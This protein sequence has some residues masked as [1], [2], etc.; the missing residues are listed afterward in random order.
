VGGDTNIAGTTHY[1]PTKI[2]H[3]RVGINRR[4]LTRATEWWIDQKGEKKIERRDSVTNKH[5]NAN[6]VTFMP[7]LAPKAR[8]FRRISRRRWRYIMSESCDH[9]L[10][11]DGGSKS[12]WDVHHEPTVCQGCWCGGGGFGRWEVDDRKSDRVNNCLTLV[13]LIAKNYLC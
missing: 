10:A 4:W 6:F 11:T 12:N 2:P 8:L 5:S 13:R 3:G 9:V 1:K 7:L